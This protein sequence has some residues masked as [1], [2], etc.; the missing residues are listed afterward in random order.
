[1]IVS[2]SEN[3]KLA[4][5]LIFQCSSYESFWRQ[6]LHL[7]FQL[8]WAGALDGWVAVAPLDLST[9]CCPLRGLLLMCHSL[10]NG[11]T[12]SSLE[13]QAFAHTLLS[14][15]TRGWC[16]VSPPSHGW[17]YS[18]RKLRSSFNFPDNFKFVFLSLWNSYFWVPGRWI[19]NMAVFFPPLCIHALIMGF[20][21]FSY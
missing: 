5:C 21:T 15:S 1:M 6:K 19:A 12:Q 13:A 16:D 20:H 3:T 7:S 4:L 8:S 17:G 11:T 14:P 10:S 2:R 9:E 18:F